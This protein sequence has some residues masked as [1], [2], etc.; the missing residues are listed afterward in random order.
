MISLPVSS[1]EL[2]Q[3]GTTSSKNSSSSFPWTTLQPA[4]LNIPFPIFRYFTLSSSLYKDLLNVASQAGV[5][6]PVNQCKPCNFIY[7]R[8]HWQHITKK[9]HCSLTA[10][11]FTLSGKSPI[12]LQ[13]PYWIFFATWTHLFF[14][15]SVL[16]GNVDCISFQRWVRPTQFSQHFPFLLLVHLCLYQI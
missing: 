3:W 1:P 8:Q 7:T 10:Y 13:L 5:P 4:E 14:P 2:L 6:V 9:L 11:F 12:C 16:M 15:F